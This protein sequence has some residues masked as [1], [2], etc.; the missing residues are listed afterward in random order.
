[1]WTGAFSFLQLY[2]FMIT[3]QIKGLKLQ[4][5][6]IRS[7]INDFL[8]MSLKVRYIRADVY[9]TTLQSQILA[10][11]ISNTSIGCGLDR[12]K[13]TTKDGIA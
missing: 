1:M 10:A 13:Y 11:E 5:R 3:S 8:N 6:S 12:G 7:N 2:T 4:L 9:R